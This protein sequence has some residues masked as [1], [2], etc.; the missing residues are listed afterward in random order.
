MTKIYYFDEAGYTGADLTNAE[1]P[2]FF[3][4]SVRFTNDEIERIKADLCID[5]TNEIH[6]KRLYKSADG[7]KKIMSI[8][9]HAL[10]DK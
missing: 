5:E 8:L 6:F 9:T 4:A 3:L 10:V 7:R 1:Q 2:Y